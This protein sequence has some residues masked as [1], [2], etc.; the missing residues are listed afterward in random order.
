[1]MCDCL[2]PRSSA[3]WASWQRTGEEGTGS[4]RPPALESMRRLQIN[5]A[6][7]WLERL[8]LRLLPLHPPLPPALPHGCRSACIPQQC[9]GIT[10]ANRNLRNQ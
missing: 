2:W 1:M 6:A 7:V 3:A 9:A 4:A 10:R 5:K 8:L